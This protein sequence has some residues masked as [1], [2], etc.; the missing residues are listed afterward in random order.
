MFSSMKYL[1]DTLSTSVE[2]SSHF[3]CLLT[4]MQILVVVVVVVWLLCGCC[5]VVVWLL[6]GCCVVVVVVV[7]N[8]I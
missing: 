5:V 3:S 8:T 4:L 7:S 2:I 6:C 1:I